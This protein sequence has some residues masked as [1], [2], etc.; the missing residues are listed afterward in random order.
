MTNLLSDRLSGTC[1]WTSVDRQT[2]SLHT[3]DSRASISRN[4]LLLNF[5]KKCFGPCVGQGHTGEPKSSERSTTLE[6][7]AACLMVSRSLDMCR[8]Q[9]S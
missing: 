2:H 5:F 6:A 9:R 3:S 4:A 8:N 1:N 7:A